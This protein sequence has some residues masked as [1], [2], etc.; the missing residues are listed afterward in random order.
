MNPSSWVPRGVIQPLKDKYA[1]LS[2]ENSDILLHRKLPKDTL[3]VEAAVLIE[4]GEFYK[5]HLWSLAQ[6]CGVMLACRL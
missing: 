5:I 2:R 1:L 3:R 6:F 4:M